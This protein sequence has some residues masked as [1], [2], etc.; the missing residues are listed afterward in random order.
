MELSPKS[1]EAS[2]PSTQSVEKFVEIALL[3]VTTFLRCNTSSKLHSGAA[4]DH[5]I[6]DP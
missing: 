2:D 4:F 6:L 3:D 1:T 5:F